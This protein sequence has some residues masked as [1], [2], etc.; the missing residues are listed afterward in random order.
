MRVSSRVLC[1]LALAASLSVAQAGEIQVLYYSGFVPTGDGTP[2][3][4]NVGSEVTTSIRYAQGSWW[5]WHPFGLRAFGAQMTGTFFVSKTGRYPFALTSDDGSRV[6]IDGQL[7]LD[8]GDPHGPETT[9]AIVRL[10]AGY[11][12]FVLNFW[13][14][15]TGASGVD[16]AIP[17]GVTFGEATIPDASVLLQQLYDDVVGVGPGAS[18]ANKVMEAQSYYGVPDIAATCDVLTGFSNEVRAQKNKKIPAEEASALMQD[19]QMIKLVIGC[20]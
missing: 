19:A 11:H 8:N 1:L 18:L 4:N 13:E 16:F 14:D 10:T 3:S 6:Y 9:L 15:G 12:P 2:F 17:D 20:R 7:A 5:S